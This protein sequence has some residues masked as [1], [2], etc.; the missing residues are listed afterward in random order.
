[1]I[2]PDN[3]HIF[4]SVLFYPF[5]LVADVMSALAMDD[6][7]L[8]LKKILAVAGTT[9]AIRVTEMHACKENSIGFVLIWLGWVGILVGIYSIADI[10]NAITNYK[11]NK[12]E[13]TNSTTTDTA[14]V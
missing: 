13:K 12:D 2:V 5:R 4:K 10:S 7:G 14:A 3:E 9:E 8:S 6:K 11:T 1:M